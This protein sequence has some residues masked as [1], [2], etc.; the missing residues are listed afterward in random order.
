MRRQDLRHELLD[1]MERCA[2]LVEE[3]TAREELRAVETLAAYLL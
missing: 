1:P 3:V 2:V